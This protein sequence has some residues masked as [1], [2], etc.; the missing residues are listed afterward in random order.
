MWTQS[1]PKRNG[2]ARRPPRA[3]RYWTCLVRHGL[4]R[5]RWVGRILLGSPDQLERRLQRLVVLRIRRDVGLRAGLLLAVALE[6]A[7]QRGLAARVGTRLE[8]LGNV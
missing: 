3:I 5:V 2:A 4:F 8:L 6:V 7:A 1:L